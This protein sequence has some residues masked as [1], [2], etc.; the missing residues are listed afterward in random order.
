M[1]TL[2]DAMMKKYDPHTMYEKKECNEGGH[3]RNC[4]M[5]IEPGR[6]F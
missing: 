1:N 6:L 2:L 3:A 4:L 5:W